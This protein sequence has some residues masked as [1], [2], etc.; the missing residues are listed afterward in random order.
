MIRTFMSVSESSNMTI[1]LPVSCSRQLSSSL[2]L[3]GWIVPAP[4]TIRAVPLSL[5]IAL[6]I[7]LWL[8]LSP[9]V[10]AIFFGWSGYKVL[11][12]LIIVLARSVLSELELPEI[13]IFPDADEFICISSSIVSKRSANCS[14]S[15]GISLY[16]LNIFASSPVSFFSLCSVSSISSSI[17]NG[18]SSSCLVN[19]I[20]VSSGSTPAATSSS[21]TASSPS[22]LLSLLSISSFIIELISEIID[23][24]TVGICA[25]TKGISS[26]SIAVAACSSLAAA[27][28][29]LIAR[30]I[31]AES[32]AICARAALFA[33]SLSISLPSASASAFFCSTSFS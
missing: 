12:A 27:L 3:L 22:S 21:T 25:V 2:I 19:G 24:D 7:P 28:P 13:R 4:S 32:T 18:C 31:L 5:P 16:F 33:S 14:S 9:D 26:F 17:V 30:S 10:L 6:A 15:P 29:V 23:S 1:I 20:T 11:I 8:I